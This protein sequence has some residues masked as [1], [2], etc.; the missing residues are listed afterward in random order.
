MLGDPHSF[1][2]NDLRRLCKEIGLGG[3]GKRTKLEA[4]LRVWH[5]ARSDNNENL[6]PSEGH[7]INIPMNV[8]GN[9]ST[10]YVL[11]MN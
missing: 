3:N 1:S 5:R 8:E 10:I 6:V 4:R 11:F 2:Y 7:L 9:K